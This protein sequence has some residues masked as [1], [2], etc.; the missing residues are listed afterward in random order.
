MIK[1]PLIKPDLPLFEA[2]SGPFQ[3][4]LRNGKITNFG[5]YVTQFEEETGRFL[6]V[7]TATTPSGTIGLILTLQAFGLKPGEKVIVP[8]FSFMASAQAILYAG[9][10]PVFADIGPDMTLS[11][12]DLELLLAAHRDAAFVLPVHLYGLPCDTPKI[13]QIA[14]QNG[15]RNGAPIRVVYDAAHAFGSER[16]GRRVGGFGNAE[17]FS[18]SVTKTLVSVEGGLVA[19][20]DPSL[21]QRVKKMRNY[22]IEDHYDAHWPGLNGKMSEFHA[23]IGLE[24]LK[25]IGGVLSIRAEKAAGYARRIEQ[26]TCFRPLTAPPSVRHTYKDFTIVAPPQL[27]GSRDAIIGFLAE[28]GIETRGYFSPPIHEQRFFRRFADR[29]LPMTEDLSRRVISLPFYTSISD[30]EIAEVVR[31]L[32][33][34]QEAFS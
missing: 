28:Q 21:I 23:V 4:I 27:K 15:E 31:Q 25:T 30:E 10:V 5:R 26:E 24:N 17:V 6:G 16:E 12:A 8:S 22:G 2:I 3:E 34:A 20:Q 1:I 32:K 9:G 19:S 7:H 14:E 18:L 13:R 29:A 11:P 33:N